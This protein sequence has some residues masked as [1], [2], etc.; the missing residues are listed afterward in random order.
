MCVCGLLTFVYLTCC[1]RRGDGGKSRD[2]QERLYAQEAT[3]TRTLF[4]V[5]S[6][7]GEN[8]DLG[9]LGKIGPQVS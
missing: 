9:N 3:V 7:Q 5:F 4:D 1:E 6:L 8:G 2:S